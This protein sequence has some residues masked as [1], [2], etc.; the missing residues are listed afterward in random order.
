[1]R[2]LVV[3]DHEVLAKAIKQAFEREG[4]VVDIVHT[5]EDGEVATETVA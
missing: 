1:M 5:C 3:E 2:V 4:Y